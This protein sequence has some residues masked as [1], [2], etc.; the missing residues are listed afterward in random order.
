VIQASGVQFS[1]AA[2]NIGWNNFAPQTT[3]VDQVNTAFMNGPGHRANILGAYNQV[4]V[5]A[6]MAPGA[7]S[8]GAQ[9]AYDGVIMYT[10]IFVQ[11]PLSQ[12]PPPPGGT[13]LFGTLLDNTA[14]GHVEVHALS[15]ASHYSQF[16]L[17]VAT[18]FVSPSGA[19]A[20]WQFLTASFQ[21]D[22]QPDLFGIHLRNTFS[23]R[24]EVHVLSAASG[25]QTFVLHA[26]TALTEIP[27]NQ[28]QFA[29]GR[30]AGDRNSD[31]Y[32]IILNNTGSSTVEVHVLSEDSNYSTW[33]LHS[34]SGL[35]TTSPNTWQFRIG[36]RS[37]SG[38]LV[39]ILHTATG[40]GRTEVH[41]LSRVSG[42]QNFSLHIATPLGPTTDSQFVYTLGDHDNDGIPDLYAVL[43][44][45]S[46]SGQTEVHVIS[47]ASNYSAFIEQAA[48]GLGPTSSSSRTWQFS[49]H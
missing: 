47:G 7:W 42:Y 27:A 41:I 30:F 12:S 18:A 20:E 23:H 44:N 11:G 17:H 25:Y 6:F 28:S 46:G 16:S 4:G 36:D 32:A 39:G 5:G 31:L 26:A 45:G 37:G 9:T 1:S 33:L 38:D 22:G 2:E 35:G 14:S 3:S 13:N 43:M 49:A 10:E 8:G 24:V 34:A 15:Q 40:S 48:S 29:V 21:G 19:T